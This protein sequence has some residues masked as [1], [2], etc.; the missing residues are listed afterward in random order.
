MT[1]E[2]EGGS[3][4]FFYRP[5]LGWSIELI[6]TGCHTKPRRDELV[7][8]CEAGLPLSQLHYIYYSTQTVQL[9]SQLSISHPPLP[10]SLRI[11]CVFVYLET[12]LLVAQLRQPRA[13]LPWFLRRSR[14][15]HVTAFLALEYKTGDRQLPPLPQAMITPASDRAVIPLLTNTLPVFHGS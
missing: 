1:G 6:Q 9:L 12:W 11:S 4:G 5:R 14:L 2:H 3:H 8:G 13:D 7:F 15:E 10:F